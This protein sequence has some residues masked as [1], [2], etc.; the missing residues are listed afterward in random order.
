MKKQSISFHLKSVFVVTLVTAFAFVYQNCSRSAIDGMESSYFT[1]MDVTEDDLFLKLQNGE[2]TYAELQFS[3][4][5]Y[6]EYLNEEI[7]S[8]FS[9]GPSAG[10]SANV[11]IGTVIQTLS[12]RIQV[13]I[14]DLRNLLF[15]QRLATNAPEVLKKYTEIVDLLSRSRD[16]ILALQNIADR[17]ELT[18]SIS[19]IKNEINRLRNDFKALQEAIAEVRKQVTELKDHVD[20]RL[21][22]LN[23]ALLNETQARQVAIEQ[24]KKKIEEEND[25]LRK[26]VYQARLEF[27][28]KIRRVRSDLSQQLNQVRQQLGQELDSVK[29]ITNSNLTRIRGLEEITILLQQEIRHTSQ[30][31]D[32]LSNDLRKDIEKIQEDIR[33]IQ[34]AQDVD[35]LNSLASWNCEDDL[36]SRNGKNWIGES[37]LN[38][39]NIRL[40]ASCKNE[41]EKILYAI[42]SAKYPQ[43]C[44]SCENVT[45]PAQCASW[46][47]LS[48]RDKSELLLTIRQ[49]IAVQFLSQQSQIHAQMIYGGDQCPIECLNQVNDSEV[50]RLIASLNPPKSGTVCSPDS[51]KQCGL[52]GISYSLALNDRA[53]ETKIARV[54]QSL[55]SEIAKL[56]VDFEEEKRAVAQRFQLQEEEIQQKINRLK[57][58]MEKNLMNIAKSLAGVASVSGK[59]IAEQLA[60]RSAVLAE[61]AAQLSGKKDILRHTMT[62]ATGKPSFAH[63]ASLVADRD[64]E[65]INLMANSLSVTSFE[66][67]TEIFKSLNP[68]QNNRPFYDLEFQAVASQ[69]CPA[70]MKFTPFTNVVGRDTHEILAIAYLRALLSGTRSTNSEN[71]VIFFNLPGV[72]SQNELQQLVFAR[73]YDYRLNPEANVS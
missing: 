44:E 20:M 42:C 73:M 49:E 4:S 57:G 47:K 68:D 39:F 7:S 67:L 27:N 21:T 38:N 69:E 37:I 34:Y 64:Q 10:S 62:K 54:H 2:A 13:V 17:K 71:N 60:E 61:L 35:H 25:A 66:I 30:R 19:D 33:N 14:Q 41:K 3:Q 56:K 15:V 58:E 46:N 23:Q 28:K 50:R 5:R 65:V 26:E 12:N 70:H 40:P 11:P 9:I 6:H 24:L 1:A 16:I 53:L 32:K 22:Q 43:F 59:E 51:W 72:V 31:L 52:Y 48:G 63:I 55:S 29:A 45:D 36:I 18:R 8:I